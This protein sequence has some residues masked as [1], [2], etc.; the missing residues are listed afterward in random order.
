LQTVDE[1]GPQT[2]A[3]LR[4][5]VRDELARRGGVR[6]YV[7]SLKKQTYVSIRL[8]GIGL[9]DASKSSPPAA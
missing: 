1:G 2:L 8:D 9:A 6:R 7:D 5:A 4:T 3:E